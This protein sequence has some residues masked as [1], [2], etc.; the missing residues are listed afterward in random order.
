MKIREKIDEL[1]N[2]VGYA[3]DI[4]KEV[5]KNLELLDNDVDSINLSGEINNLEEAI[6]TLSN[7]AKELY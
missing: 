4:V 1:E 2:E 7:L 3:L 5:S 6:G